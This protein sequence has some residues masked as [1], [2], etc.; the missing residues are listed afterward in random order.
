M[1][2]QDACVDNNHSGN[3]IIW[4]CFFPL[5]DPIPLIFSSFLSWYLFLF[6]SFDS[7]YC[8]CLLISFLLFLSWF[9]FFFFSSDSFYCFCLIIYFLVYLSWYPYSGPQGEVTKAGNVHEEPTGKNRVSEWGV[10][11]AYSVGNFCF[12]RYISSHQ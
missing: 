3:L 2:W 4:K 11:K 5:S 8:F 9:L 6:F 7:F 10:D 12:L 1:K